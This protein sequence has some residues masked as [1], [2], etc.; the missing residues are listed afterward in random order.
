MSWV[1]VVWS[2]SAAVCLTL[3][4]VHLGVWAQDRRAWPNLFFAC[5]A[6]SVAAVA[7]AELALM[8]SETVAQLA[9]TQRWGRVPLTLVSLSLIGFI[10]F[11]L[12]SGRVWLA[13]ALVALRLLAFIIN[14]FSTEAII[15]LD[16]VRLLGEPVSVVVSAPLPWFRL[17]E[18]SALLVM[19]FVFDAAIRMWRRGDAEERHRA[20]V[21]GGSVGLGV[22]LA[23]T[24]SY[25][26]NSGVFHLPY[27]LA[28]SF[29]PFILAMG[30][31]L[32]RDLFRAAR[33]S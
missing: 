4:A 15:G 1:T 7:G 30:F 9:V 20:V 14:F 16:H 12:H 26:S 8:R 17:A 6:V 25:L 28:F 11:Y 2:A 27:F 31:E 19:I 13:W 21:I 22:L 24:S 32:S 5:M 10:S 33:M 29:M 18:G 23:V 3:G